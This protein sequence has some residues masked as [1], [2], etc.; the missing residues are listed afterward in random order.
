VIDVHA[1][2]TVPPTWE[3]GVPRRPPS[4]IPALVA[5]VL[6]AAT[7]VVVLVGA[8][9]ALEVRYTPR[10]DTCAGLDAGAL[11]AL[12]QSPP[13]V[14]R[15]GVTARTCVFTAGTSAAGSLSTTYAT[16]TFEARL[17]SANGPD[18]GRQELPGVGRDAWVTVEPDAGVGTCR[19]SSVAQDAN[20]V[21][22][23]TVRLLS[24]FCEPVGARS[25]LT[26]SLR[27]TLARLA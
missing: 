26:A 23:L 14:A 2:V 24:R 18:D 27:A 7:S 5:L 12:A 1:A 10:A 9:R 21:V 6:L 17:L 22:H 16:S 8:Y 13:P 19:Y 11:A 25:A 3:P 4:P 15:P 20:L